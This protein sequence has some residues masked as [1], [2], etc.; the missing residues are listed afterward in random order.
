MHFFEALLSLYE[1]TGEPLYLTRAAALARLFRERMFDEAHGALPEFYDEAWRPMT[2]HAGRI[3]EPGHHFE[4]C[5]LLHRFAA[6]GGEDFSEPAERLRIH[7]ETCGVLNGAACDQVTIDGRATKT[8][9][10]LWPQTERLKANLAHYEATGDAS[11]ARAALEAYEML[12]AFCDT[13]KAGLWYDVRTPEGVFVKE[14]ARAS[15]FYHIIL[16]LSELFRV[17]SAG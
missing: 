14:P 7:A 5:W 17:T 12:R 8:T 6:L 13:P 9:A 2:D 16:A 4:W 11:A 3:V 1:A 10:R 15:S